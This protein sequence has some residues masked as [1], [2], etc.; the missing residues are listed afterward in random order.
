MTDREPGLMV[1]APGTLHALWDIDLGITHAQPAPL[2]VTWVAA[3]KGSW[4]ETPP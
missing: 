4:N 3:L 2:D 1:E